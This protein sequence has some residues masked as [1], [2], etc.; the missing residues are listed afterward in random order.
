M[1]PLGHSLCPLCPQWSLLWPPWWGHGGLVES[2]PKWG[3][4]LGCRSH[5]LAGLSPCLP[6]TLFPL[7]SPDPRETDSVWGHSI[8]LGGLGG[9]SGWPVTPQ[10]C[11]TCDM[12]KLPTQLTATAS[13]LCNFLPSYLHVYLCSLRSLFYPSFLFQDPWVCVGFFPDPPPHLPRLVFS[14]VLSLILALVFV[15]AG[16]KKKRKKINNCFPCKVVPGRAS[17]WRAM[18]PGWRESQWQPL[19][20]FSHGP[21]HSGTATCSSKYLSPPREGDVGMPHS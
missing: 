7:Q 6:Y 19:P 13:S 20:P 17:P 11:D 12:A 5:A 14:S 2:P 9:L 16:E 10:G 1:G 3:A 4:P 21:Q 8:S 18:L 15:S